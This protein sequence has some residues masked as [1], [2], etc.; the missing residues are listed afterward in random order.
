VSLA[1]DLLELAKKSVNYS[2]SD[3]L[4]ARLRRSVS[5]AYYALFHLLVEAGAARLTGH[6]GLR[7]LVG[8]AFVHAD[9]YKTAKTFKSGPGGLP[10]TV[11]ALGIPLPPELSTV[12]SA[13]VD[14]QDARHEADYNLGKSFVRAEARDLVDQVGLA[15]TEWRAVSANP[16][17]SDAC[18]LFLAA[19]LLGQRWNK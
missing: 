9:M 12:A 5:T 4:D 17:H 11:S 18:D 7:M 10:A 1:D 3:V 19:L 13:F 16:A 8:R 15:F 2:R 6:P 14:I